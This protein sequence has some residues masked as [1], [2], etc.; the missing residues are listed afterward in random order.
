MPSPARRNTV[1]LAMAPEGLVY[2]PDLIGSEE[3]LDL[4]RCIEPLPLK[5]FEFRGHLGRRRTVSFGW[6]YDFSGRGLQPADELPDFLRELRHKAAAFA[7]LREEDLTQTT[8]IEYSPGAAIGWHRDRP[9]FGDVVGFSL[10]SECVFRFRRKSGPGWERYSMTPEP[11]SAYLLRGPARTEW[12][13][14]IPGVPALRYA[15]TFRSL[16]PDPA[17][18]SRPRKR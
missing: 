6:R 3:E 9:V 7:Q 16:R 12:E 1:R 10:L 15:I 2:R 14:S 18:R 4:I 5:E 11:R 13:H 17:E 8:I